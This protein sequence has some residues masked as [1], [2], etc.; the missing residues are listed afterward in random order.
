MHSSAQFSGS[1]QFAHS[2][3]LPYYNVHLLYLPD[4]HCTP[5]ALPYYS[6]YLLD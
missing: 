2:V 4:M 3:D 5:G 6:A 1:A